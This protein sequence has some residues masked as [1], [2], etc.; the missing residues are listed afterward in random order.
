MSPSSRGAAALAAVAVALV[1][2]YGTAE[3]ASRTVAPALHRTTVV[4]PGGGHAPQEVV[5][6][7]GNGRPAPGED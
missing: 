2:A 4:A 1:T 5:E 6:P 3:A 7:G